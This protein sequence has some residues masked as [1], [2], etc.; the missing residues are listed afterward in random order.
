METKLIE[1]ALMQAESGASL[2]A[3]FSSGSALEPRYGKAAGSY[4]IDGLTFICFPGSGNRLQP[5]LKP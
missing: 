3:A 4:V 1:P 2:T 5:R